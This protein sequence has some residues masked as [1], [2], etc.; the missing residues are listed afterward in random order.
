MGDPHVKPNNREES[1]ALMRFVVEEARRLNVA[2]LEIL[3]D[4]FDTHSI[5][6]LEVM[7]FWDYWFEILSLETFK[8]IVLVGNHDQTGSYSSKY[9]ALSVFRHVE[10]QQRRHDQG[11][12][13]VSEPYLDGVFGYLPYIHDNAQFIEQAN[14][15]ADKGATVLVS[16][17]NFEGAVYDNGSP[18]SGGV[19][20]SALSSNFLHLIGGHIHTEL[21]LGRI[22]YTG[23][24]RWLTKSCANKAKG[25]WL[26]D[27]DAT[28]LMTSKTFISTE[29]VCTPIASVVWREGEEKPAY[30]E[31][32]NVNVE[33]IGSS[34]WV[35]K[36]KL[37]L[38]GV[39]ISS[40][41]TDTKKSRVRKSGKSLHEFLSS[42]YQAEPDKRAK[43]LKYLGDLNLV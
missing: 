38:K 16:H 15:L 18:L 9:S 43:L 10:D 1:H 26:C 33:L 19:P 13:I 2:V 30:P 3:G 36:Q 22:W 32:G 25:I 17:P 6:R 41:L 28:G 35:S 12:K 34:D 23:N 39:S 42:H 37:D 8:T 4:L 11:I 27:H 14:L 20:D 21:S 29:N 24:P 31:K 7:E 5:V 40:K